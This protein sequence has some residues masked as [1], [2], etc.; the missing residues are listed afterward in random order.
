MDIY[1]GWVGVGGHLQWV[2]GGRWRWV[3]VYFGCVG[4]R[5]YF[6]W[7]RFILGGSRCVDIFMAE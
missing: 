1:Y 2:G 4:V 3:E 7:G 5:E 6:L